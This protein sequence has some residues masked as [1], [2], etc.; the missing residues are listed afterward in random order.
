MDFQKSSIKLVSETVFSDQEENDGPNTN[1]GENGGARPG[2]A[3]DEKRD[4][5]NFDNE[6]N[7]SH[8]QRTDKEDSQN[9]DNV[10]GIDY[11]RAYRYE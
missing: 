8:D 3:F 9:V 6:R 7:I 10:H 1:E 5:Q 11:Q 4:K 2:D